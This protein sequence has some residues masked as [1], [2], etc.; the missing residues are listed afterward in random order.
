MRPGRT[1]GEVAGEA[2]LPTST[3]R[4]YERAGLLMQPA[5]SASNYRL[6]DETITDRIGFIRAAQ[7]TGFTLEDIKGLLAY[8]DGIAAPCRE[9]RDLI[10]ARLARVDEKM[11][12]LRHVHEVLTR[13]LDACRKEEGG[14]ECHVL[15]RPETASG[16]RPR[17]PRTR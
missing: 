6:Y 9:I 15:G 17:R 5:R 4:Y 12:E 3:L 10:E 1:I 14:V 8:R 11:S 13:F 16:K 7:S 2:G